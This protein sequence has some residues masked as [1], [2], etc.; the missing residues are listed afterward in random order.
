VVQRLEDRREVVAPGQLGIRGVPALERHAVLHT[1]S[2]EGLLT[3]R[4]RGPIE[5]DP[6]DR[7]PG[8]TAGDRAW[9][10]L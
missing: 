9:R 1:A 7:D 4:D 6:V 3:S 5:V 2:G 8:V 10:R